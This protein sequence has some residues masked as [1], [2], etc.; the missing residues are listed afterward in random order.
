MGESV[1]RAAERMR[2]VMEGLSSVRWGRVLLAERRDPRHQPRRNRPGSRRLRS[3][4][5]AHLE[6]GRISLILPAGLGCG[7]RRRLRGRR[8]ADRG[9]PL[10]LL[11][12]QQD[13]F[14]SGLRPTVVN[15]VVKA[16]FLGCDIVSREGT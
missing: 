11:G 8:Q 2:R 4:S 6:E 13:V 14:G 5:H 9:E 7:D 15:D 12:Q 16:C 1:N 10:G 3:R